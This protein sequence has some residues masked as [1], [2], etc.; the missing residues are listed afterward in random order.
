MRSVFRFVLWTAVCSF[1][2]LVSAQVR[3]F[4]PDQ[5][6]CQ[7]RNMVWNPNQNGFLFFGAERADASAPDALA[8]YQV[9]TLLNVLAKKP[10]FF[11]GRHFLEPLN[12]CLT[13]TPFWP[14]G[15]IIFLPAHRLAF[16]CG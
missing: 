6:F 14:V 12:P 15:A 5:G 4:G 9:D 13:A 2:P 16:C 1:Y 11:L 8:L 7:G 3:V 10:T